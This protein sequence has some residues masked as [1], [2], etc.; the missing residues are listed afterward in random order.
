MRLSA[1]RYGLVSA[2]V[3]LTLFEMFRLRRQCWVGWCRHWKA[4]GAGGGAGRVGRTSGAVGLL[5]QSLPGHHN[6]CVSRSQQYSPP[7]YNIYLYSLSPFQKTERL[8]KM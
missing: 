4:G 5:S 7:L 6:K 1:L 2:V 8:S 3:Q